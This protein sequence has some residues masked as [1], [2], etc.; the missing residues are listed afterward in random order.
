MQRIAK[1]IPIKNIEFIKYICPNCGC[2]DFYIATT[3]KDD[4]LMNLPNRDDLHK[5]CCNCKTIF[6]DNYHP[7]L[8][9]IFE[10]ESII[11][12]ANNNFCTIKPERKNKDT[13]ADLMRSP[14]KE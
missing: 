9:L 1:N 11:R 7:Y 8:E 3:E 12:L 14:L 4:P 10:D 13:F 6:W 2:E 5:A